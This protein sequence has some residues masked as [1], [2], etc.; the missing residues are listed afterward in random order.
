V[1]DV[2]PTDRSIQDYFVRTHY[3]P[4]L[5]PQYFEDFGPGN[6]YL[7]QPDVYALAEFLAAH[8]MRRL[9]DIGCGKGEKLRTFLGRVQVVGV[10]IG[11]NIEYCRRMYLRGEWIDHNLESDGDFPFARADLHDSL[12][13][14]ADVIEHLVN[15]SPLLRNLQKCAAH[16]AFIVLSTPERDLARGRGDLGPPSNPCHV[17][18]WTIGELRALLLHFGFDIPFLGLTANNSVERRMSTIIAILRSRSDEPSVS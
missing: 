5:A 1:S 10:D 3:R 6:E 12:I 7:F 9:I 17:R 14:C 13:I 4:R 11:A 2:P 8:G 15:P 16:G 18:E